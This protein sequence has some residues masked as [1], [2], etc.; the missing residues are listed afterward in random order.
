MT[1]EGFKNGETSAV[2]SGVLDYSGSSQ[3]A[4]NLGNYTIIP[5]GLSDLNYQIE[6][7]S[8]DLVISPDSDSDGVPEEID[9]CPTI[10]N[11]NQLDRIYS[12]VFTFNG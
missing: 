4:I 2:L 1:Y 3:G 11:V 9:N 10:S 7:F 12:G 8:N 6:Y 5:N